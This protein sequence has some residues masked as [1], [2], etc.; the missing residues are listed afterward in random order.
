MLSRDIAIVEQLELT[1]FSHDFGRCLLT[2]RFGAG[3]GLLV[4]P[5][6]M[7][8]LSVAFLG[9]LLCDYDLCQWYLGFIFAACLSASALLAFAVNSFCIFCKIVLSG[10]RRV[11]WL[12][13]YC[14][15]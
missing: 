5:L 3:F 7:L 11:L 6:L 15:S 8:L 10:V 2:S 12:G 13:R 14:W 4:L 9:V 1:A